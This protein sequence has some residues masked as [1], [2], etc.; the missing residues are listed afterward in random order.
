MKFIDVT[1][2]KLYVTISK[3]R[4]KFFFIAEGHDM[5]QAFHEIEKLDQLF[6]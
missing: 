4:G 3:R 2:A 5:T 6:F 1:H